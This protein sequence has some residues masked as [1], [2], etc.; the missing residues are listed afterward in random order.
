MLYISSEFNNKFK[1][2]IMKRILLVVFLSYFSFGH[3]VAQ[4]PNGST[5]PD[6][7]LTDLN[8]ATQNLYSFLDQGYTV[9]VD[10]SAVWCGPCWGYHT[11]GALEDLYIHHGPS[12]FPNVDQNTTDDAMVF[13]VEGDASDLACL[14]GNGCGTQGDWVTGTPYP[15]FCTD[16]TVNND[17]ITSAYS[18]S[19]WPTIYMICPD[20]TLTEA[21]QD[22]NPYNLITCTGAAT[23]SNDPK[24]LPYSGVTQT[25]TG[26]LA[27]TPQITVQNN[28][29]SNLTTL[30]S[31]WV[32]ATTPMGVVVYDSVTTWTGN[33]Q[34][35]QATN[36]ILPTMTGINGYEWVEIKIG[37]PNGTIDANNS[38]NMTVFTVYPGT[39]LTATITKNGATISANVFSGTAPYL[40]LWSTGATT[41][42]IT[43]TVGGSYSVVVTDVNGCVSDPALHVFS[44]TTDVE[45]V[46]VKNL[47]VYPNPLQDIFNITF[48]STTQ[49]DLKVRI[50]NIIGKEV[51]TDNLEE[52]VGKYTKEIN[53]STYP[54]GIYFLE[55]NSD[56]GVINKKVVLQ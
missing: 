20:R 31:I 23:F 7:T 35:Y 39:S 55:I 1:T 33:L 44:T 18:I 51:Y 54:K 37:G 49:Q 24:I 32:K 13:F 19:Y 11:S 3:S 45:E 53:F 4:L 50:L 14:H 56:K 34:T 28:G 47:N 25:C 17:N 38:N 42:S 8:G 40:Y 48:T 21:G 27:L 26:N 6:F 52:F 16:G 2:R 15:I 41:Q 30:D 36:I 9:F 5:A 10:F 46:N 12:G 29:I 43:P 22:P